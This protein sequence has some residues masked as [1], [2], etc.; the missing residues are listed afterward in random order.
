MPK[1][2]SWKEIE[3]AQ[4]KFRGEEKKKADPEKK[5]EKKGEPGKKEEKNPEKKEKKSVEE[6]FL[7]EAEETE[8][9]AKKP[10]EIIDLEAITRK[11]PSLPAEVRDSEYVEQLS[12]RPMQE[13][14]KEIKDIYKMV[15]EKG[16]VG[17]TEERKIEYLSSAVQQK[18]ED[19]AAGT[20]SFTE[21]AA[22]AASITK[23][24]SSSMMGTY[25]RRM[26]ESYRN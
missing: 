5:G 2:N 14:Y 20:Y 4:K 19:E 22:R 10:R 13:I 17:P 15:E 18:F 1:N 12:H 11:E 9:L 23:Q 25:K 16:Y 3:E 21:E 6:S 26:S 7:E 24:L 8:I